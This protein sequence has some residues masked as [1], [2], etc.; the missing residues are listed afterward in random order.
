MD[1]ALRLLQTSTTDPIALLATLSLFAVSCT[2]FLIAYNRA[3]QVFASHNPFVAM[4]LQVSQGLQAQR[5]ATMQHAEEQTLSLPEVLRERLLDEQCRK[6][7]E[8][9][10]RLQRQLEGEM[11]RVRKAKRE[12][13]QLKEMCHEAVR[14]HRR[15]LRQRWP[16]HVPVPDYLCLDPVAESPIDAAMSEHGLD[17]A[18][19]R[20][21]Q[22]SNRLLEAERRE[23]AAIAAEVA[24]VRRLLQ[25]LLRRVHVIF[26][27]IQSVSPGGNSADCHLLPGSGGHHV[28]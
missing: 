20:L 23:R 18:I 9:R 2:I 26:R 12:L 3:R 17:D 5:E 24:E 4:A 19:A 16:R 8:H 11:E 25:D 7:T 1:Q 10:Q 15:L 22:A 14:Q 28:G 13:R 6:R 21:E 27:G